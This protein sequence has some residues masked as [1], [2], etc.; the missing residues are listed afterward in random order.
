[1]NLASDRVRDIGA[2]VIPNGAILAA[3]NLAGIN[4]VISIFAS[5]F[6]LAYAA[7][8]WRRDFKKKE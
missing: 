7:W 8:R 4:T 3:V 1:M 5:L 2:V 6:T